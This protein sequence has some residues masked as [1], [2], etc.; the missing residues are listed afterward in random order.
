M[1]SYL[2]AF[3]RGLVWGLRFVEYA[4]LVIAIVAVIGAFAANLNL[5]AAS[6][7]FL[8]AL[9]TLVAAGVIELVIVRP[10]QSRWAE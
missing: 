2:H 8:F 4:L 1:T 7:V 3:A 10:A 5:I 6:A 9:A